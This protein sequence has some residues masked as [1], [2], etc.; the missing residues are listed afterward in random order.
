MTNYNRLTILKLFNFW[1]VCHHMKT[2]LKGG[3]DLTTV[4]QIYVNEN[5]S[6]TS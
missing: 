4:P 2:D 5:E 3:S 6:Y 1:A